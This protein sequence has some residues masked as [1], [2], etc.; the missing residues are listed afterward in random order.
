M[1]PCILSGGAIFDMDDPCHDNYT[2]ASATASLASTTAPAGPSPGST[3]TAAVHHDLGCGMA[4]M[5]DETSVAA[6]T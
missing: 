1:H 2:T 3:D 4:T 5:P 6:T